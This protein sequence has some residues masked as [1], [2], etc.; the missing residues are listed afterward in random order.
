MKLEMV[1]ITLVSNVILSQLVNPSKL[2]PTELE[3]AYS[4]T[5]GE[6]ELKYLYEL[7]VIPEN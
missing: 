1:V 5:E 6:R 4:K 7:K 3:E 2:I